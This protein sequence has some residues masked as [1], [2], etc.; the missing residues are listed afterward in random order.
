MAA[1]CPKMVMSYYRVLGLEKEPFSTSPD[2]DFLFMSRCHKAALFRLRVALDL[3]R[4]M[5][6]LL[7]DV[8]TGKTTLSR[9]LAKLSDREPK[10]ELHMMLNPF[11]R[12]ERQFLLR[13]ASL[14]GVRHAA[15]AT[16]FDL[17]ENIERELFRRGVEEDRT[18][19]LLLDEAQML[20]DFVLEILR[21]LLNYETNEF[22]I[23]QL[24]LVGQMELL[25][26]LS[27]IPNFWDR[28][29]LKQIIRPLEI[30]EVR[31]VVRFRLEQA[32]CSRSQSLFTDAA[33]ERIAEHT[34]G[35]PRKVTLL[36]H[37]AL[38]YLVMHD[39]DQVDGD[40]VDRLLAEEIKPVL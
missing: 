7:G 11:F 33:I 32:G 39:R 31:A 1:A 30:E 15:R 40:L 19:I 25:P 18:V 38:E 26:R 2:P 9:K 13:L 16:A 29:A 5:S 23:L 34:A 10:M 3:R 20:P 17:M 6:I 27:R 24:I 22:K 12:T 21:I 35:Y 37:S 28:I 14:M 4:G 36:C 8:G